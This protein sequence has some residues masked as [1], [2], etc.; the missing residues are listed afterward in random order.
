MASKA[1]R[2]KP[3]AKI[4]RE[5]YLAEFQD[6]SNADAQKLGYPNIEV[7]HLAQRLSYIAGEWRETKIQELVSEYRETL[8]EMILK[9]YNLTILPIEDQLPEEFMPELP[10]ASVLV[11]IRQA[12]A[13]LIN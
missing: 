12:Y 9:G 8:Y 7:F 3:E 5:A 10:P 1:K 11:A 13:A 6:Y 4:S 2:L